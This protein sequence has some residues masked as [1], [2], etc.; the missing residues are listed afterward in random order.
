ML[1]ADNVRMFKDIM[2]HL[3]TFHISENT[4]MIVILILLK[5][6]LTLFYTVVCCNDDFIFLDLMCS[7]H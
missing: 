7:T 5:L 4:T 1:F 3:N 6:S 2:L